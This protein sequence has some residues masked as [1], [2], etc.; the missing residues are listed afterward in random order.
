VFSSADK[1]VTLSE[2]LVECLVAMVASDHRLAQKK[3]I[4]A[5]H[6]TQYG[7]ATRTTI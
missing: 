6:N 1:Q 2:Q 7:T 5:I 3:A 4:K